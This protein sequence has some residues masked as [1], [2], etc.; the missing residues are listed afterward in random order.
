MARLTPLEIQRCSFSR[1]LHG[2]KPEEVSA[3]LARIAEQVEDDARERGELKAQLARLKAELDDYREKA[4]AVR[5]ALVA[6]ERTAEAT[7][8]RAEAEAARIVADAQTLAE[9]V[10]DEAARRAETIELVTGQLRQQRRAARA[11]LRRLASLLEG[12]ARDDEAAE[13]REGERTN[14]AVLRPRQREGK[15]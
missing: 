12:A 2:Y 9:R 15:G 4:D 10:L 6:A 7:V 3:L 14:L 13:E 11:D 8:A 5:A 1:T